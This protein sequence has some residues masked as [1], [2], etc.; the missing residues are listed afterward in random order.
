M[1]RY[2][3]GIVALQKIAKNYEAYQHCDT[4]TSILEKE[5]ICNQL[6]KDKLLLLGPDY[7]DLIQFKQFRVSDKLKIPSKIEERQQ[8]WE[9]LYREQ[10]NSTL[11]Q[12]PSNYAAEV[13]D[14]IPEDSE[15]PENSALD[16]VND[17]NYNEFIGLPNNG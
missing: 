3:A 14:D 15:L 16:V 1:K 13:L 9:T 4:F 7:L 2:N 8:Q 10:L 5:K 17:D 12:K 11:P 6:K